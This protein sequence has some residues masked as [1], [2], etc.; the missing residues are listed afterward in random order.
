[1]QLNNISYSLLI[2]LVVGGFSALLSFVRAFEMNQKHHLTKLYMQRLLVIASKETSTN[3]IIKELYYSFIN[4]RQIRSILVRALKGSSREGFEYIY[5]R[6]GCY[7]MKQLHGYLLDRE[8]YM[9]DTGNLSDS[10]TKH[11]QDEIE[12]WDCEYQVILK[13]MRK[14][15][16][17]AWI[18]MVVF[19][20]I[21]YLMFIHLNNEYSLLI[22]AIVNTIGVVNIIILD[23]E[24]G[25]VGDRIPAGNSALKMFKK[26]KTQFLL[27]SIQG[28]YQMAVGLGLIYNITTAV[29]GWLGPIT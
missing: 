1:M 27:K 25:S 11:F 3:K 8:K 5:K 22:F 4:Q 7:P 16:R 20:F 12:K 15:R 10:T 13:E 17:H 21:N 2:W 9:D 23:Y 24:C 14:I 29:A 26:N 6:I 28:V 19:A 18:N